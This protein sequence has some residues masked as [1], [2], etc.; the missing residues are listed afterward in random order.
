[1]AGGGVVIRAEVHSLLRGIKLCQRLG[2][3]IVKVETDSMVLVDF[4]NG[5]TIWP[6]HYA[7]HQ[8]SSLMTV[9]WLLSNNREIQFYYLGK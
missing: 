2:L 7:L 5:E 3:Q 4:L 1:M 6:C 8:I 9:N